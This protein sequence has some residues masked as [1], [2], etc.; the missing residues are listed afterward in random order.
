MYY[1]SGTCLVRL[2][3]TRLLWRELDTGLS[4]G[5]QNTSCRLVGALASP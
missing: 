1:I 2:P 5:E 4:A 3:Q